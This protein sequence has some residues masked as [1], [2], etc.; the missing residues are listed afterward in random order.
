MKIITSLTFLAVIFCAAFLNTAGAQPLTI[1][2]IAGQFG[3]LDFTGAGA[4]GFGTNAL[5][6]YPGQ[7]HGDQAGN[8]YVCDAEC[9]K[10]ISPD[11]YV[12]VLAGHLGTAPGDYGYLDGTGANAL[13]NN[14]KDC[15]IDTNG[16]VYVVDS[17]NFVIRKISSLGAVTTFAGN[18][19]SVYVDA[20]GTNAGFSNP[21]GIAIDS[22][23]ILYVTDLYSIGNKIREI[24]PAGVVSTLAGGPYNYQ[25]GDGVGTNAQFVLPN[26]LAVDAAG[27]VY[28][29]DEHSIR[30]ISPNG[31][32][33]TWVGD[34]ANNFKDSDGIGLN[35][36]FD[37]ASEIVLDRSGGLY[38]VDTSGHTIRYVS[39]AGVVSTVAGAVGEYPSGSNNGVG[40]GALFDS[41]AGITVGIGGNVY[42][43]D[44]GAS[45]ILEGVPPSLSPISS[46]SESAGVAPIRSNNPWQFTAVF[47]DIVSDLRLR[48]QST[49]TTNIEASWTDLPDGGQMADQGGNWTLNTTDVPTGTRYFRVIAA[50]PGYFDS[51]SATVGPEIVLDGIAPFGFFKW[52]TTYPNETATLWVFNIDESSFIS[53]L[54]L[55]VQANEDGNG[56]ND[57]PDGHMTRFGSTWAL[58]TTNLPTGQV[59][60]RVI[61]SALDYL[62]RISATLGPFTIHEPLPTAMNSISTGGSY[63]LDAYM[64]PDPQKIYFDAVQ[65]AVVKFGCTDTVQ[66]NSAVDLA[67]ERYAAAVLQIEQTQNV[68]ILAVNMGQNSTLILKG[69][70]IGDVSLISQD[71][72]G[73]VSNDGGSLTH[74]QGE[75]AV[76]SNDGG[77][78]ISQDGGGLISQDGGGLISQDGGGLTGGVVFHSSP[79]L[80][81]N[82]PIQRADLPQPTFIGQM[83][84]T[85]NYSQFPGTTLMIGIAGTNTLVDGAQ[86]YDQLVVSDQANLIG[87][88]IAFELFDPDDQSN[89]TDVFQPPVGATFDVVVASNIVVGAVHLRG[90]VWGD[91]LFF[92]GSV[93]TRP[94]GLQAL[95]LMATHIPPHLFIKP[96]GSGVN[97]VYGTNYTGYIVES[98]PDLV[99][100]STFSTGTNVVPLSPTKTGQFFRL[101]KP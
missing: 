9:I 13:F 79:V 82:G 65:A 12:R 89:R 62:D 21:Q 33:S 40:S 22:S 51:A 27:T 46:V 73:V 99:N 1:T 56:W 36:E 78:L 14:P 28:V 86:Q 37:G 101:S 43:T 98:S 83:A 81:K 57:L 5:F 67:G 16:N 3:V 42:L 23:G 24:T 25:D 68:P 11:H 49:T 60:F 100:W 96:A 87:G 45:T 94:D 54:D 41:P 39:A 8:L 74:D 95:R 92:K 97:L 77:S 85:G 4:V 71:G 52:Q 17:G 6:D 70:I 7:L 80:K 47:T 31:T 15:A 26:G 48:V 66:Y 34:R 20:T 64:G 90:P 76:I 19:H 59:S 10:I 55:R 91:G 18:G 32:V 44:L 29:A 50:A 88:T 61:A 58:N 53:G 84:I 75:A 30:K 35:A 38:V 72:S 93:V 69:G 2:T 63:T